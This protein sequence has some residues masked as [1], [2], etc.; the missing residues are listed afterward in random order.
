VAGRYVIGFEWYPGQT[1]LGLFG[2]PATFYRA[3]VPLPGAD[4]NG[5]AVST[6]DIDHNLHE[7]YPSSKCSWLIDPQMGF[8][9]DFG[10]PA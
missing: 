8:R 9:L 10:A 4:E 2:P 1:K 6:R 5:I 7:V 3:F